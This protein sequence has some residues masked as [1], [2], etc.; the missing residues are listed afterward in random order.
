MFQLQPTAW[1]ACERRQ[2]PAGS[3]LLGHQARWWS[4]QQGLLHRGHRAAPSS[5]ENHE[6]ARDLEGDHLSEGRAGQ[7]RKGH[8]DTVN[9]EDGSPSPQKSEIQRNEGTKWTEC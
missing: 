5:T 1:L 4:R 8:V 7:A 3:A 9:G 6:E 2:G